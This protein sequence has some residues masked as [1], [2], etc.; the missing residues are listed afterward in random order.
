MN[1]RISVGVSAAIVM[2]AITITFAATLIFSMR[3]FDRKVSSYKERAA[4]YDKINE[5][6]SLVREKFYSAISDSDMQENTAAGY[7]AG[8]G[9]KYSKYL[10]AAEYS[11]AQNTESGV[12]LSLGIEVDKDALGYMEIKSVVPGSL[13][14]SAGFMIGDIVTSIGPNQVLTTNY[15]ESLELLQVPEGT[16]VSITINRNGKALTAELVME[17]MATT[18]V[19]RFVMGN[20]IGY[21]RILSF[22]DG[23]PE[24]F[25][26]NLDALLTAGVKGLI[27][28]VRSNKTGIYTIDN[29]TSI[30]NM[31][32]PV[33]RTLVSGVYSDESV[34]LLATSDGSGKDIP[35]VVIVNEK[36][37]YQGELFA[38]VLK[39][40]V[41][42]PI[43]GEKTV[44]HG[45][46]QSMLALSDGS[47]LVISE[48]VFTLPG[49]GIFNEKGIQPD[50]VISRDL[51]L[52]TDFSEPSET[53]DAQYSR[54]QNVLK[55]MM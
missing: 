26:N 11:N 45:T 14:A 30:L 23:A 37:E 17:R 48:A 55:S 9:D 3:M 24:Q 20:E 1:K 52:L 54:A 51:T 18:A 33:S 29:V 39:D 32:I 19:T 4:M 7:V 44:G 53:S 13:A 12:K 5:I 6:D 25:K 8:L 49:S 38:A 15:K 42:A 35:I 36:T 34:K 31:I 47:A 21:I 2:I 46:Y 28:D 50:Y 16:S 10:T 27:I 41:G 22:D 43:V 40:A